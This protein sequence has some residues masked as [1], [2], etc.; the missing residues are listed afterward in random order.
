MLYMPFLKKRRDFAHERVVVMDLK[1][2]SYLDDP[3]FPQNRD[4][5]GI[6]D[7][8]RI[9]LFNLTGLHDVSVQSRHVNL[10]FLY[11]FAA[12]A[13]ACVLFSL[14]LRLFPCTF[15]TEASVSISA[16]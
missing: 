12:P 11:L 8:D 2:S 10:G 4:G 5:S 9:W 15:F 16:H 6:F 13:V 3:S 1:M 7:W 14:L